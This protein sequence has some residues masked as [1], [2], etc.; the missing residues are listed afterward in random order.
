MPKDEQAERIHGSDAWHGVHRFPSAFSKRQV[1]ANAREEHAA[2]R[3][4]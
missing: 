3:K 2:V 1:Q 4:M